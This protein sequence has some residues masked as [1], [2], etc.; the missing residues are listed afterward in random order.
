MRWRFTD[1]VIEWTLW[2]S[3]TTRKLVS[4]EEY[5]LLE[6]QGRDG[7]FPESL[8]LESCVHAVRWLA[9]ASTG[10][11]DSVELAGVRD[12]ALRRTVSAGA[13]LDISA[14]IA[15]RRADGFEASCAVHVGSECVADGRLALAIAPAAS[16]HEVANLRVLWAEIGGTTQT[17]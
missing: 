13:V 15:E 7:V 14:D 8:I 5:S 16:C 4:L 6:G 2:T 17:A 9:L 1:R 3:I 10:F 11:E 12:F